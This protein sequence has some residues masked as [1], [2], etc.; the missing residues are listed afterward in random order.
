MDWD[1]LA[2]MPW[3]LF[4]ATGAAMVAVYG[5]AAL[6]GRAAGRIGEVFEGLFE[7]AGILLMLFIFGTTVMVVV[8]VWI[9]VDWWAGLAFLALPLFLGWAVVSAWLDDPLGF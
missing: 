7:L 1:L 6:V 2:V 3:L 9:H 5:V 8:V 4:F